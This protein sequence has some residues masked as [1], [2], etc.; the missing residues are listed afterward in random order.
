VLNLFQNR[1]FLTTPAS[2]VLVK[3]VVCERLAEGEKAAEYAAVR[4]VCSPP[5]CVYLD[6]RDRESRNNKAFIHR[7]PIQSR[8]RDRSVVVILRLL[9]SRQRYQFSF[10]RNVE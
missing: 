5:L 9:D 10:S 8:D 3:V 7:S 4:H 2:A 1:E 6:T